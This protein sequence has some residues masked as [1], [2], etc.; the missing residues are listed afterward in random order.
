MI[1]LHFKYPDFGIM[2]TIFG[3]SSYM[4]FVGL[5]IIAGIIYYLTDAEK[6]SAK[7][8]GAIEIVS[9][10]LIFGVIGS[11]I[12][13]II[14]GADIKTIIYGKS[15]LGGL[16][17]GMLGVILIKRILK[18]K[19]KMGN[20]IAPAVALGM[21]IGRLGCFFNGCCYGIP[22][23]WGID[24]GDGL[25]RYP[26]Q[27]FESA[28]HLTAFILLHKLKLKTKKP[29]ILFK[30][31][32]LSYFIFRFFIEFIRENPVFYFGLTLYQL[33]CIIGIIFVTLTIIINNNKEGVSNGR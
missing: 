31:Y 21:S 8:E 12:P 3:V 30:Y 17:G 1:D 10:A 7:S 6:R 25:L 16:L 2:P 5:G 23:T 29:G 14:E 27:L 26:T 13:L 4:I 33:I 28:F 15:I 11:K 18:I 32:V 24:F 22:G 19:T 20:I 9:S